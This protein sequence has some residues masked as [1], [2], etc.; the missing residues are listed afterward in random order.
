V[1]ALLGAG[2]VAV[3]VGTVL[4]RT[5]ESGASPP[6]KAALT[7]RVDSTT[8]VTRAFTG[9]PA[10]GIANLF[11]ERYDRLAPFGYPAVHHLTSPIRRAAAAAGD[12]DRINLWAGTG[13]RH[14]SDG[15]ASGVLDRLAEAT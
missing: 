14:A 6:Y 2:A 10:R 4:L 8:I 5:F 9:R 11:T 7:T 1:A 15:S 12:S 3:L 13:F